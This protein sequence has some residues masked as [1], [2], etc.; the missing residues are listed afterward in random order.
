LHSRQ[1][2][3]VWPKLLQSRQRAFQ[4]VQSRHQHWPSLRSLLMGIRRL[5]DK[6]P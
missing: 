1:V 4:V 2:Q 5:T 3:V 6:R